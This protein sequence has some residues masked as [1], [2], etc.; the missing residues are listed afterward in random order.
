MRAVVLAALFGTISINTPATAQEVEQRGLLFFDDVPIHWIE[1]AYRA[2]REF[3]RRH[4]DNINC[5]DVLLHEEED[6]GFSVSFAP[7]LTVTP[8][9]APDG[10]QGLVLSRPTTCGFGETFDYGADGRLVRH[11]YMRH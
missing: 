11:S 8:T 5:F 10:E 3:R 2:L 9:T 7:K 1:P 6:G 4:R